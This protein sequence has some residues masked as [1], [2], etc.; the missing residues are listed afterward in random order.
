[1]VFGVV[2]AGAGVDAAGAG[3]VAG[4]GAVWA[5]AVAAGAEVVEGAEVVGVPVGTDPRRAEWWIP[6]ALTWWVRLWTTCL[7]ATAWVVVVL[8]AD[9]VGFEDE[10][11]PATAAAIPAIERTSLS[12]FIV[13]KDAPWARL[14]PEYPRARCT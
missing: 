5:G 11:Q 4:G 14:L 1:V 3:V 9:A 13:V 6:C 8:G 12:R 10:P 2:A 7:A